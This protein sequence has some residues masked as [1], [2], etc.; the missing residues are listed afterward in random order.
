MFVIFVIANI[1]LF[2]QIPTKKVKKFS[3]FFRGPEV[4]INGED[5]RVEHPSAGYFID[6][7]RTYCSEVGCVP[8]VVLFED[9]GVIGVSLEGLAEFGVAECASELFDCVFVE[10][11]NWCFNLITN[12][13]LFS[14]I[15]KYFGDFF[16]KI[17]GGLFLTI[18]LGL[19]KSM[20]GIMG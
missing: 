17:L 9:S 3:S 8:E 2:F 11:F 6:E 20:P 18:F 4:L 14:E 19:T 15:K 7:E 10:H 16:T 5:V 1:R 12:I 13:I